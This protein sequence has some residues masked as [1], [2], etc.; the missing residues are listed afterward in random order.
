L[1]FDKYAKWPIDKENLVWRYMLYL[2]SRFIDMPYP[3]TVLTFSHF[4][5]RPDLPYWTH[6]Q[7]LVKAVGC[8]QLDKQLREVRSSCH[9]FGHSHMQCDKVIEGVRYVQCPLG[10]QNE[11]SVD[12]PLRCVYDGSKGGLVSRS[13]GIDG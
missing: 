11:H 12:E 3:G 1:D 9:V 7:G 13:Q 10:Y 4:L 6:V 2:N 8:P 5:P